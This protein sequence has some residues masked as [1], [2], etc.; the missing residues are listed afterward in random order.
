MH[1]FLD[2]FFTVFH[3]VLII[4]ILSGWIWPK[5]RKLN[6]LAICLTGFSWFILGIWYGFGY[7]FCTDWHWQVRYA[8]GIFDMP[9]SYVK[10]LLD[11]ITG[12]NW[13]ARLVDTATLLLFIS[14]L[15]TSSYVNIRD[16]RNKRRRKTP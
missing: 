5:T 15:V 8:M 11:T 14:A 10:F 6:F 12:L 2:V 13:S 16:W 3:S 7:C 9:N 4:F 1:A